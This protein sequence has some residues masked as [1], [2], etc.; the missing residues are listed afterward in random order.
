MTFYQ[1]LMQGL[2]LYVLMGLAM[3]FT[4]LLTSWDTFTTNFQS[5]LKAKGLQGSHPGILIVSLIFLGIFYTLGW[6]FI[7][8]KNLQKLRQNQK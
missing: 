5:A 2:Q 1:L 7:V 6:V 4:V 8:V 3:Y